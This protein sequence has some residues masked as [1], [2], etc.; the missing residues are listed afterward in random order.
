MIIQPDLSV[1]VVTRNNS[2][3]IKNHL[4]SLIDTAAPV[5]F[6]AIVVDNHSEDATTAM[7]A[8][9]FPHIKIYENT[10]TEPM[11][12]ARNRAL[13]LAGG[14]YISVWDDDTVFHPGCLKLLIDFMDKTPDAGIVGPK[15]LDHDGLVEP[16]SR[17]FP[18]LLTVLM[19]LTGLSAFFPEATC[20]Q[21]HLMTDWNHN[22]SR[23]VDWLVGAG[24]VIRKEVIA[25]VG[26]FDEGFAG[27]LDDADYCQRA[28]KAG[29]HMH[30]IHNATITHHN[31][32]RYTPHLNT[33]KTTPDFPGRNVNSRVISGAS[34][35]RFLRK[36]WSRGKNLY[37]E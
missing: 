20:L 14:R 29:W 6:E 36:K 2:A 23:E 34:A 21:K 16:S 19:Q 13:R 1:C 27:I 3:S 5:S 25:E 4:Q 31:P 32:S 30:Y 9:E 15:V 22:T 37:S 35:V 24:L 26:V 7:L 10:L 17:T 18:T 11:P 33:E 8:R 12:R 28:G